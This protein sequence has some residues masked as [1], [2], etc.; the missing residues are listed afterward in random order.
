[1][2][3][4]KDLSEEGCNADFGWV[5]NGFEA[6]LMNLKIQGVYLCLFC[7]YFLKICKHLCKFESLNL[8]SFEQFLLIL[9]KLPPPLPGGYS[10]W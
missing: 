9:V 6:F 1:M 7:T 10:Q 4:L 8:H 5:K 2:A 3:Q